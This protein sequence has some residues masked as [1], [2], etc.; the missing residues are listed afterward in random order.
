MLACLRPTKMKCRATLRKHN[1]H[2]HICSARCK[3]IGLAWIRLI[4]SMREWNL[5]GRSWSCNLKLLSI[6][7]SSLAWF[8]KFSPWVYLFVSVTNITSVFRVQIILHMN[9]RYLCHLTCNYDWTYSRCNRTNWDNASGFTGIWKITNEQSK[10][11]TNPVWKQAISYGLMARQL[12]LNS[13]RW[14]REGVLQ[15]Y[16]HIHNFIW[17]NSVLLTTT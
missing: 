9:I 6:R 13:T 17:W 8:A 12:W 5:N 15:Q 2:L 11:V 7:G 1:F 16:S 10:K 3:K 4:S 14:Y